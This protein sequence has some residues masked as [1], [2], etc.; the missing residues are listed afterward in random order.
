MFVKEKDL[1][2]DNTGVCLRVEKT[3]EREVFK[4]MKPIAR[5]NNGKEFVNTEEGMYACG[6]KK[7]I[8]MEETFVVKINKGVPHE[9]SAYRVKQVLLKT[10]EVLLYNS[11]KIKISEI[12]PLNGLSPIYLAD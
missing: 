3:F 1:L 10:N 11:K 2:V 4:K 9:F 8:P 12:E 6:L 5:L 7:W